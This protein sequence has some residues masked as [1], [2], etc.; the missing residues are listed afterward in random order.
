MGSIRQNKIESVIQTELSTF[1]QRHASDVCLGS[2]VTVT[3]VRVTQ[4]LS[5]AR[6]YLS[7]FLGPEKQKVLENIK[8]NYGKIRGEIGKR[9]KNMHKIPELTFFIDDSQEYAQKI[10]ELLKK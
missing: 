4:D 7:F 10:E 2:M 3:V 9:L 6:C 8:A 5:L 1:F